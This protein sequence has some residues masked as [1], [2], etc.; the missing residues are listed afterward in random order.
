MQTDT[1]LPEV[2][3]DSLHQALNMIEEDRIDSDVVR[4]EF[5]HMEGIEVAVAASIAI[6][7]N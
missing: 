5:S 3:F 1:C 7:H 6:K 4:Q 2:E